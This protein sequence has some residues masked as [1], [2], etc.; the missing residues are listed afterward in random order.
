[1]QYAKQGAWKLCSQREFHSPVIIQYNDN[2]VYDIVIDDNVVS[3]WPKKIKA[4]DIKRLSTTSDFTS[5]VLSD[6]V[7]REPTISLFK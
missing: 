4:K 7:V 3:L 1:M 5:R 2:T 6:L